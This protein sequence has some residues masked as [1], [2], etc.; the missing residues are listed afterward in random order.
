M[1]DVAA[2]DDQNPFVAQ[3]RQRTPELVMKLRRFGCVQT[4]LHDR[5]V[6]VRVE[7]PQH[8]PRRVIQTPALVERYGRDAGEEV[9]H[10]P[11]ELR[12]SRRGILHAIQFGRKASEI[13]DR[14]RLLGCGDGGTFGLPMRGDCEDR[15]GPGKIPAHCGPR[16]AVRVVLHGIHRA[17][18]S[19]EDRR[20]PGLG[21]DHAS[22]FACTFNSM[23][24][25]S[26]TTTPPA[27]NAWFQVR[28]KSLRLMLA[29]ALY[30]TRLPPHGSL[31]WPSNSACRT[32]SRVMP[33]SVSSPWTRKAS[34]VPSTRVLRY[35][36]AGKRST[37]RKSGDRRWASRCASR[38]S[39]LA[40]SMVISTSWGSVVPWG[41]TKP[42][43]TPAKRPR[44]LVIMR[45]RTTNSTV[46]WAGS[47]AYRW[48]VCPA[49]VLVC[50]V[51]KCLLLAR[52][53]P[54]CQPQPGVVILY[55]LLLHA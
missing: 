3:R 26:P 53:M 27:S 2:A 10:A 19:E 12:T 35:V 31:P 29:C 51:L 1:H 14:P 46:V 33:C 38:V 50:M 8:R 43:L 15:R 30:P 44:T 42:P 55:C 37:S 25:S 20:H 11:S 47:M 36:I 41:R 39:T 28:P 48:T 5:N 9:V 40:V 18:V 21:R 22:S 45:W 52:G 4:E 16:T 17:A 7:M 34:G 23:R 24:T 32:T 49:G 6:R 13:V 54:G